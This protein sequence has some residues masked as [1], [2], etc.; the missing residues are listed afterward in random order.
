VNKDIFSVGPYLREGD[1]TEMAYSSNSSSSIVEL[2][3]SPDALI[4][5]VLNNF[6]EN[7]Y[8]D[9]ECAIVFNKKMKKIK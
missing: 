7:T 2:I 8:S 9:V 6:F 5:L 4:L 3:R 1:I